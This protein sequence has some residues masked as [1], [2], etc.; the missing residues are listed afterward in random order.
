MSLRRL[1]DIIFEILR[2]NMSIEF[3]VG[4]ETWTRNFSATVQC[5]NHYT[6]GLDTLENGV[7][8]FIWIIFPMSRLCRPVATTR[9]PYTSSYNT[10]DMQA[11]LRTFLLTITDH[12]FKILPRCAHFSSASSTSRVLYL[13]QIHRMKSDIRMEIF[14]LEG[15][16][17]GLYFPT[18]Q[19]P[20]NFFPKFTY[21]REN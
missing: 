18:L 3:I 21:L 11:K 5:V 10:Y 14:F 15:C 16:N 9:E 2:M 13:E 12:L 7:Y 17:R 1:R 20:S 8:Y 6:I 4:G 19:H